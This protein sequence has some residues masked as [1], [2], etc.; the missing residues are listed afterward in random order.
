M[1]SSPVMIGHFRSAVTLSLAEVVYCP[2]D[3][4]R[5]YTDQGHALE[6]GRVYVVWDM[7]APRVIGSAV[8]A[9]QARRILGHEKADEQRKHRQIVGGNSRLNHGEGPAVIHPDEV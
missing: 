2:T 1:P 3:G 4:G 9:A 7:G 6:P 8:S 5:H